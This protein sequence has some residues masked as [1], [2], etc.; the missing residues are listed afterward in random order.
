MM[1]LRQLALVAAD[2]EPALDEISSTLGVDLCFRDP[3]VI[4]FG[5]H[6]GLFP[7]GDTFLEV[8]SPV[9]DGTTAGRLL[10]KRKGDGGYMVIA[11]TNEFDR[12]AGRLGDLGIR[13]VWHHESSKAST[14]HMHPK[15]LGGPIASF[16]QMADEAGW[17]WAGPS[18]PDHVRTGTV[19]E[20]AGAVIGAADP[21]AM[22]ARW[23]AALDRPVE[24]TVVPLDRGRIVF[25]PAGARGEG[26]DAIEVAA[27]DRSRVGERVRL[28]GVEF[29]FV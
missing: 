21:A 25:E 20:L 1:R 16:D 19:T 23:A 22:A 14:I 11:Q 13:S 12:L 18:W 7:I 26:L 28:V 27:T 3:G 17:L 9:Q 15:D 24:G 5:L 8:I 29:R 4:E 10:D 6:N 2:L